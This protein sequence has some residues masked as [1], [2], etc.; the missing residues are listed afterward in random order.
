MHESKICLG[1]AFLIFLNRKRKGNVF[2][3][4]KK[5]FPHVKE[6]R[7]PF[8]GGFSVLFCFLFFSFLFLLSIRVFVDDREIFF[9]FYFIFFKNDAVIDS[10]R[11]ERFGQER[12]REREKG[13]KSRSFSFRFGG[14]G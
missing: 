1:E 4:K 3:K 13:E 6:V 12:E 8:F 5:N 11:L 14:W 10:D 2:K 7:F 9:I